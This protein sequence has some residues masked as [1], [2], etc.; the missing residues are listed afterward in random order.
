MT[1]RSLILLFLMLTI[2]WSFGQ[3]TSPDSTY[4][5]PGRLVNI[6]HRKL[7][8]LCSGKGSPTVILVAGGG[9]FSID[10]T[11]VQ[12]SIDSTT[13][14]C[15]YDRAG[16][17]WSDPGPANET[18]EQTVNDLH[19]LLKKTG[20]K[21]PYILVGASIA[22]IFIQAYQYTYP[23]EVA[24]LIFTNSSDRLGLKS[25]D[26]IDL[27]WNLTE[28]EIKSAYPL[29]VSVKGYPPSKISEPFN[30][31]PANMQPIRVWLQ[32]K[33]WN[34]WD[35]TKTTAESQLSW[36]KEFLREFETTDFGKKPPL[37]NL[38]VVVISSGP[39]ANDSIR[40]YRNGAGARLDF[41][42][43]NSLHITATGSGH[44]IH[45]YQPEIVVQALKQAVMAVRNG[46]PLSKVSKQAEEH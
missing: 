33:K 19:L 18:I 36:R 4:P 1:I 15:S 38:P 13:R 11:L 17:G 5:P 40:K 26:K 8:L 25:K 39:M 31:L 29:P 37:G 46:I 20:E 28:Q 43:S 14:V 3:T 12:N 42:S 7:H 45:L 21:G 34:E 9:A 24:S 22:G 30:R 41:L 16:L 44:E 23:G 6:G 27:I 2:N 35:P 32:M 10:W